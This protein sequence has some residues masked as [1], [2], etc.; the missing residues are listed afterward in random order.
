MSVVHLVV[1]LLVSLVAVVSILW[2]VRSFDRSRPTPRVITYAT[3]GLGALACAPAVALELVTRAALGDALLIGGRFLDAFVV[4]ALVEESLKLAVVLLYARRRAGIIDV[5]DGIV[6]CVAAS[7]GFGLLENAVFAAT[8]PHTAALRA[9]TAVPLHAVA[10][11][12]MG[13]GVGRSQ[14]VRKQSQVAVIAMGLGLAVLIHGLYD[15]AVFYRGIYWEAQS[16]AVLAAG[17][18]MF[19]WLLRHAMQMDSAMY[20]PD[21]LASIEVPWPANITSTLV[22]APPVSHKAPP[23][24]TPI[25]PQKP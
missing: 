3:L 5:M 14:F 4:A 22:P 1:G 25:E 11:G 8:D 12:V 13:Y 18:M 17:S 20:G 10:S 16:L 6:Y 24:V 19:V 7:L 2:I 15:W 21:A 9:V 23:V